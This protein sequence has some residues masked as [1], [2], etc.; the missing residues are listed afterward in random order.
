MFFGFFLSVHFY[1]VILM[2]YGVKFFLFPIFCNPVDVRFAFSA[3]TLFLGQSETY[4]AHK[5]FSYKTPC[6]FLK[7]LN[8]SGCGLAA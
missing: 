7:A 8:V 4:L 1:S 6:K 2:L 5:N 3:L